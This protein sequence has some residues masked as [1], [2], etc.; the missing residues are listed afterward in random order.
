M[1][2]KHLHKELT[3]NNFESRVAKLI[4][5]GIKDDDREQLEGA[6]LSTYECYST[7]HDDLPN[8]HHTCNSAVV[9]MRLFRGMGINVKGVT[10]E[11]TKEGRFI[12]DDR[13]NMSKVVYVGKYMYFTNKTSYKWR[14][15]PID[16][17]YES[18]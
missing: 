14:L 15:K 8:R 5:T 12:A 16:F 17:V 9:L 18:S 1:P 2:K 7:I 6:Y 10:S 4:L 13:A 11:R 3:L